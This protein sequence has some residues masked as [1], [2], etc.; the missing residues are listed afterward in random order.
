MLQMAQ[1]AGRQLEYLSRHLVEIA[2]FEAGAITISPSAVDLVALARVA[3]RT[4]RGR[5]PT[6]LR[7]RFR[8]ALHCRDAQRRQV[9][10]PFL[11]SGDRRWLGQLFALLLDNA[12]HYS[13]QGGKIDLV[14]QPAEQAAVMSSSAPSQ[15]MRGTPH[16]TAGTR[17]QSTREPAQPEFEEQA[18]YWEICVCDYG[19]GIPDEHLGHIF[20]AFYRVDTR[21]TREFYGVGLSLTLCRHLVTLHQGL[22]WAE[23]CPDGGSV[24]HVLLP[25]EQSLAMT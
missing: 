23:S 14:I 8:F 11:V 22:I 10:G 21:L 3:V 13:P 6:P 1:M 20:D 2:Q 9:R 24:F 4:A 25:R 16:A 15:S 12:I 7:R 5:V 19:I 18:P 17:Y